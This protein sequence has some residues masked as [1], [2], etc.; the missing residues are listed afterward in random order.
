[1]SWRLVRWQV[2]ESTETPLTEQ[3]FTELF[4]RFQ[5][6]AFRLETRDEY[7]V[8]EEA[9]ILSAMR[10]GTLTPAQMDSRPWA[11]LVR[12]A[13]D[14]G[15]NVSRVHVV[16]R[17]LTPYLRYEVNWA[18]PSNERAGEK[19]CLLD[20]EAASEL[21]PDGTPDDYWLFDDQVAVAMDYDAAGHFHGAARVDDPERVRSLQQTKVMALGA[22]TPLAQ[23]QAKHR[24]ALAEIRAT[25]PEA[26]LREL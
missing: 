5:S 24:A 3:Q 2:S 20:R 4:D 26:S 22:A 8:D 17:K 18:Y 10:D 11:Q 7:A 23:F 15:K 9:G 1:M 25:R 19:V 14:D 13:T 6:S 21:F 16:S 12:R